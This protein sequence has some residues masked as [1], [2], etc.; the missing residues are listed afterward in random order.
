MLL[1]D[2]GLWV[3]GGTRG[4]C[5]VI[6]IVDIA[7][8]EDRAHVEKRGGVLLLLSGKLGTSFGDHSGLKVS[9]N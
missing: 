1:K 2:D 6:G 9:L 8:R 4:D 7:L 3:L 5:T